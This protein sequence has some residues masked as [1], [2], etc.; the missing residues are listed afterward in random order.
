MPG[1]TT[2][3]LLPYPVG[4]E[5]A[6]QGDITLKSLAE[7]LDTK[8]DLTN[9]SDASG[10]KR[11]NNLCTYSENVSG[12]T[13]YLIIQ[14]N[15]PVNSSSMCRVDIKG[16]QYEPDNASIDLTVTFY[17]YSVDSSIVNTEVTNRG[18]FHFS[19]VTMLSRTSDGKVAIA[20]ASGGSGGV[21]QY[22]KI[23]VDG[24]FGHNVLTE[25][26]L[27][28]GWSI[29]RVANFTG[30]TTKATPLT[31]RPSAEDSGWI[32]MTLVGGWTQYNLTDW[33]AQYRRK[34]GILYLRGLVIPP[35]GS[36]GSVNMFSL[37]AGFRPYKTTL[38]GAVDAGGT[39][40][41]LYLTWDGQIYPGSNPHASWFSIENVILPI[42]L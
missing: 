11:V 41:H 7:A 2:R 14:T 33:P 39:N 34:G 31:P 12:G 9:F 1:N 40:R 10:A 15:I 25:A 23:V 29:S 17:P 13:G 26:Q 28:T 6:G 21:W 19:S 37:P 38:R 30:Y 5:P 8:L 36:G 20:L 4:G 3:H 27:L 16:Y 24:I 18:S 35:A 22:P 32:T 42:D